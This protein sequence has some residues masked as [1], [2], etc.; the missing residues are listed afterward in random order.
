MAVQP[1]SSLARRTALGL[2]AGALALLGGCVVAPIDGYGYDVGAPVAYPSGTYSAPYYYEAPAY[3]SGYYG[4]P[5]YSQPY[6]NP[7]I[8]LGIYGGSRGNNWR[9][10]DR[11]RGN[12]N[13]RGNDR[14]RNPGDWHGN[15]GGQ[16]PRVQ[17]PPRR[18]DVRP[19]GPAGNQGVRPRPNLGNTG[20]GL[21]RPGLNGEILPR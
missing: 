18:P 16:P 13:W 8:S 4:T 1:S 14:W 20:L 17:Q 19:S 10:N 5:Y 3:G 9:G 15:R 7:S 6:Y 12:N 11:W 2:A 21:D